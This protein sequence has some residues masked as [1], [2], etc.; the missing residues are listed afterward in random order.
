MTLDPLRGD[1]LD[2]LLGAFDDQQQEETRL[3][4]ERAERLERTRREGEEIF[5]QH[6]LDLVRD[7]CQ[8]LDRAGHRVLLHELLRNYPPALRVHLWPR[9]GPLDIAEPRRH[10]LELVWGDPV[11]DQVNVRRWDWSGLGH[12][13]EQAAAAPQEV[14]ALWI[15]EQLLDFIRDALGTR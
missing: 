14:D 13:S 12:M 8:R 7:A 10:T 4:V 9:P 11:P 2:D 6:A 15:R 3:K 5:R 1:P